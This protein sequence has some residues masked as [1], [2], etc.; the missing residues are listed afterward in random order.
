MEIRK[1]IKIGFLL[2]KEFKNINMDLRKSV[3]LTKD[4]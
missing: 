4:R 1:N 3:R 2:F